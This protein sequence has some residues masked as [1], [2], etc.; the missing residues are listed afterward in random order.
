MKYNG[1]TKCI[2]V[3]DNEG[4]TEHWNES[5][6][7]II[8][9]Y[10]GKKVRYFLQKYGQTDFGNVFITEQEI[11]NGDYYAAYDAIF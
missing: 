6:K 3:R 10:V 7:N 2:C 9:L 5:L 4:S 11:I 8:P 1:L